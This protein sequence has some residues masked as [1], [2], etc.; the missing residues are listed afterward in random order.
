MSWRPPGSDIPTRAKYAPSGRRADGRQVNE[1][2]SAR[3]WKTRRLFTTRRPCAASKTLARTPRGAPARSRSAGRRAS[4]S[5]A[6]GGSRRPR[7]RPPARAD[8][9]GVARGGGDLGLDLGRRR[10]R[11][12]AAR[13][14]LRRRI[15][16]VADPDRLRVADLAARGVAH[17]QDRA[18]PAG[19]RVGVRRRRPRAGGAVTEVPQVG[20][21]AAVHVDR[22]PRVEGHRVARLGR[23]GQRVEERDRR[24]RARRRARVLRAREQVARPRRR[25]LDRL[26]TRLVGRAGVG[27]PRSSR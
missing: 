3:A 5:P 25:Q 23:V 7:R 10:G 13:V 2:R 26:A 24:R 1:P 11:D 19:R 22:R 18:V 4:R 17:D 20:R 6:R 21:P 15:L 14:G 27:I 8:A 16:G 12:V 9:R